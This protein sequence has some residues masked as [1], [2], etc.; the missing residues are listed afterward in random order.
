[1]W[2]NTNEPFVL[3]HKRVNKR[4]SAFTSTQVPKATVTG[5]L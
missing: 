1:M 5:G 2:L 4:D 3:E